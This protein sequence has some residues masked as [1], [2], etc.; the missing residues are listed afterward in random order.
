MPNNNSTNIH[1]QQ[2]NNNIPTIPHLCT[3]VFLQRRTR[4]TPDEIP[5]EIALQTRKFRPTTLQNP[6]P[7]N[8]NVKPSRPLFPLFREIQLFPHP[9][10]LLS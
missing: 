8:P 2:Y 5:A 7:S 6:Y 1:Q 3:S 9:F 4:P 10:S